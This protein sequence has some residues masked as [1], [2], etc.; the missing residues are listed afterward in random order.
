MASGR[1][2]WGKMA[3]WW[4]SKNGST[5]GPVDD[6]SVLAA[7]RDGRLTHADWVCPTGTQTWQ[8]LHSIPAFCGFIP[9]VAAPTA[10]TTYVVQQRAPKSR[11]AFVLLGLFLGGFGVHNFY[12]GYFGRGAIQLVLFGLGTLSIFCMG[13]VLY[14]VLLAWI[15]VEVVAVDSDADGQ[16]MA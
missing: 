16:A 13:W 15:I 12:A 3:H 6:E 7:L 9:P 14:I 1:S 10:H 2:V 8:Q 5:F 4:I 11:V